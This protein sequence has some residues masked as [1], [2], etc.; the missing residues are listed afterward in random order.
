MSV[1]QIKTAS[2]LFVADDAG[3][4]GVCALVGIEEAVLAEEAAAVVHEAALLLKAHVAFKLLL[5]SRV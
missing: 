4:V 1:P 5:W 3:A 2:F